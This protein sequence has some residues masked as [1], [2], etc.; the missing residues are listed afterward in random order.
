MQLFAFPLESRDPVEAFACCHDQ[1]YS[2]FL[3]SADR[4]HPAARYSFIAYHPFETVEAKDGTVTV[5]NRDQQLSFRADPFTV[6]KDRL[7]G[8]G[9]SVA[10]RADLPPFQG[11]AAGFFGY[12]LAR[13]LEK[14]PAL[15]TSS[16]PDMAVGLYDQVAAFD[17]AEN[18][19]WLIVLAADREAAEIKHA[20]FL[21]LLQNKY[22]DGA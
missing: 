18:K 21:R 16:A 14:L 19:A 5:T 9:M 8:W 22:A 12:D 7:A 3:D 1:P 11:G 20:H 4:A 2:L 17:H 13:G 15:P 10:P 6:L